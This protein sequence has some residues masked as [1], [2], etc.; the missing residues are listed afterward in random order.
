MQI[1]SL[2]GEIERSKLDKSLIQKSTGL[3]KTKDLIDN[4]L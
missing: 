1:V 2:K 4:K 3:L